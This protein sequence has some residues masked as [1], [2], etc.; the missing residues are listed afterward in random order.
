[1][2][3]TKINNTHLINSAHFNSVHA[4]VILFGRPFVKRFALCYRTVVCPILSVTLV[5]YGQTVGWIKMK[6]GT[7]V[8]LSPGHIVLDRDPPPPPPKGHSPQFSTQVWSPSTT[9][10]LETEWD[11]FR[12]KKGR[13]G[14]KKTGKA[15]E[16]RRKGKSK[17]RAKEKEVNGQGHK[18][19]WGAP[20]PCGATR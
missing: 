15:S 13:D 10:S 14:Q 17:K 19:K 4:S 6:L 5:Y 16:K 9:S 12:R 7:Q 2:I 1:M 8:G 20:G 3:K 11:Y 18:G